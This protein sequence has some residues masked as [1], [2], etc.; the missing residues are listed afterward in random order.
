MYRIASEAVS[1]ARRHAGATTIRVVVAES[2]HAITVRIADDGSGIAADAR[3]GLGLR[4]MR[5][6]AAELGGALAIS[7]DAAGTS[8]E[9]TIPRR[10]AAV[11]VAR[12]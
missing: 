5:E 4:S 1:N 11:E 2:E 3:R 9:A 8:I 10:G 12:V 7:S 6:R